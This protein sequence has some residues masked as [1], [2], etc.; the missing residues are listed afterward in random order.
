MNTKSWSRLENKLGDLEERRAGLET[1]VSNVQSLPRLVQD[2]ARI[3]EMKKELHRLEEGY[4]ANL[5]RESKNYREEIAIIEEDSKHQDLLLFSEAKYV[6][7]LQETVKANEETRKN[8]LT[9]LET[10]RYLVCGFSVIGCR[11]NGLDSTCALE[12]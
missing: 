2:H 4:T 10:A 5:K 8:S 3:E 12:D 1:Q 11:G 9:A 6:L 7:T